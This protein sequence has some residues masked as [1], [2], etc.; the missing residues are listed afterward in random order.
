MHK[1][2]EQSPAWHRLTL[3]PELTEKHATLQEA[4]EDGS[5]VLP[6]ANQCIS[7]KAWFKSVAYFTSAVWRVLNQACVA[8]KPE[9][10]S[11]SKHARVQPA[12]LPGG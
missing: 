8:S 9:T 5:P 4:H 11:H 6:S 10:A 7:W 3:L 1:G 2:W 12:D